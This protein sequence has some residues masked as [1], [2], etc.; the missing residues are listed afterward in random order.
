MALSLGTYEAGED[1]ALSADKTAATQVP[2]LASLL[3]LTGEGC[4]NAPQ[5]RKD[6]ASTL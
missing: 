6:V 4:G 1:K 2:A 3:G 5:E